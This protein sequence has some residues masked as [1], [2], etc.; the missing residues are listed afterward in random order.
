MSE[1]VVVPERLAELPPGPR[2]AAALAAIDRSRLNGFDLV[3]V[4]QSQARQV[5][6]EQ[7]QLLADLVAVAHC[8]PGG[9]AAPVARVEQISEFAADEIR[10]ALTWTRR[11]ADDQLSLGVAI[12]ERLPEVHRALA[13]G[14]IDLPKARVICDGV[15]VLE[16]AAAERVVAAVIGDA[17]GLTTGQL[18]SR[19]R[20]LAIAVDPEAAQKRH[21]QGLAERRLERELLG[22]GTAVLTGTHLP[23]G[24]AAEAAARIDTLARAAKHGGDARSLDQL[25]ADTFLDLLTGAHAEVATGARGDVVLTGA[26]REVA[27]GVRVDRVSGGASDVVSGVDRGL[28]TGAPSASAWVT[29]PT[30]SRPA[31]SAEG[32]ARGVVELTVP[33]TTLMGFAEHPGELG[34]WGPVIADVARQVVGRRRQAAWRFSVTDQTGRLLH[35]VATRRRPVTADAEF[36]RARDRTCRAPGCRVPARRSDLDHVRDWARG[37]PTTR[38]NLAALCRHDHRLK[39]EGGWRHRPIA[40]GVFAWTT[41]LGHTYLVGPDRLTGPERRGP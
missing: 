5:A 6:H 32:A 28:A 30:G 16:S 20:R 24:R 23:V 38:A 10:A 34:G 31:A 35:N 25:R 41:A 13:A 26:R 3:T 40:P 22:D 2:L 39:H 4:L 11:A 19:L 8:P 1:Q 21:D 33:L 15:A 18:R 17:P 14:S 12:V 9:P 37:G 29:H 36:V 7:A 27:T